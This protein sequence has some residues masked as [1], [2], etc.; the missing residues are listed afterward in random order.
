M[1]SKISSDTAVCD[2]RRKPEHQSSLS[3]RGLTVLSHEWTTCYRASVFTT[4]ERNG[5]SRVAVSGSRR[6][7]D[8][9]SRTR[10][11]STLFQTPLVWHFL[12]PLTCV[13][14]PTDA[15]KRVLRNRSGHIAQSDLTW[16]EQV[17]SKG[18]TD[19]REKN[20]DLRVWAK[21]MLRC[22]IVDCQGQ[23]GVPQW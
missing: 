12:R 23:V 21:T 14:R 19:A 1:R 13:G 10:R 16:R 20:R 4:A 9:I 18:R 5:S 17:T 3:A 8:L 15:S 11:I 6:K 22:A 7:P 2:G